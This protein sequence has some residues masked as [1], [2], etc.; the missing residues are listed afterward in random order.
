[1][2]KSVFF[3]FG[4]RGK[5]FMIGITYHCNRSSVKVEIYEILGKY[6]KKLDSFNAFASSFLGSYEN[7]EKILESLAYHYTKENL[8]FYR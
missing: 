1:M 7:R 8:D 2:I 6:I 5:L 3:Y 4:R